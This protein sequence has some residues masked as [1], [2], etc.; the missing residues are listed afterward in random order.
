M[1][2]VNVDYYLIPAIIH[3]FSCFSHLLC[4]RLW[5]SLSICLLR[6]RPHSHSKTLQSRTHVTT[7]VPEY[8]N[9]L[10]HNAWVGTRM[11]S[12]MLVLLSHGNHLE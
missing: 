3:L 8:A 4:E 11:H 12:Q 1:L 6:T 10:W 5:L 7:C 9:C 2:H